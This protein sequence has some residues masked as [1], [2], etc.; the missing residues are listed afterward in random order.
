MNLGEVLKIKL[1]EENKICAMAGLQNFSDRNMV[2]D[3]RCGSLRITGLG[4]M[5]VTYN[6]SLKSQLEQDDA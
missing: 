6:P 4:Y 2:W 5:I 1:F 3:T